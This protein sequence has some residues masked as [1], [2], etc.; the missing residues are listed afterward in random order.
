[1]AGLYSD[2]PVITTDP[3]VP[4]RYVKPGEQIVCVPSR[5]PRALAEAI[6]ELA[7]DS[8][9]RARIVRACIPLKKDF[10]WPSIGAKTRAVYA[11]VLAQRPAP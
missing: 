11:R 4:T 5:N 7:Y 6:K 2:I 1:M 10:A 3:V 8:D 9:A